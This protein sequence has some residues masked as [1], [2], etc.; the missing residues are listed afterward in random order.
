MELLET[1]LRRNKEFA[2]HGFNPGLR[3]MPTSKSLIVGCVDPR[4]DPMDVFKLEPGEAGIYRNV[5]GRATPAF[6]ETVQLLRTVTQAAGG[7]IGPGSNI[8]V[9]H[10]TDCGIKHCYHGAQDLLAKHM[11]VGPEELYTKAVADPYQSVAIDVAAMQANPSVFGGYTVL[12]LVYDV[13][14]GEVATVVPPTAVPIA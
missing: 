1:L 10:H 11:G 13:A 7:K 12:G 8:V 5:G 2:S 4:V 14:T 9:L 3:M 6:L